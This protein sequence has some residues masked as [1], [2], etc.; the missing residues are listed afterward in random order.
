LTAAAG[1]PAPGAVR[2]A[3]GAVRKGSVLADWL[4]ATDHKIIGYMYLITAFGFF[5][6]GGAM[7]LLIRVQPLGPDL[8]VVPDQQ[9]NELFTMHGTLTL[10]LF[11]TPLFTGLAN[12]VMPLQRRRPLANFGIYIPYSF[13]C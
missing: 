2:T 5:L 12:V 9:Y 7:A 1:T 6:I 10:L 11:A 3:P 4:S 8:H 13:H